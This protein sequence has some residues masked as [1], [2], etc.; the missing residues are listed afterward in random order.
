[1]HMVHDFKGFT[2]VTPTKILREVEALFRDRLEAIRSG[3]RAPNVQDDPQL[4]L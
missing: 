3:R 2:G 1:M 4:I